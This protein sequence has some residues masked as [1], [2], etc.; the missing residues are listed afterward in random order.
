MNEFIDDLL[1]ALDALWREKASLYNK[2][3]SDYVRGQMNVVSAAKRAL[4]AVKEKNQLPVEI[5]KIVNSTQQEAEK[6]EPLTMDQLKEMDGQPVWIVE[7]P[8]WGH[9]ELSEDAE[10]Y[11]NDRDPDFYGMKYNDPCGRYGL[12]A[13]GWLAYRHPPKEVHSD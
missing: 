6:S 3:Q 2:T 11:L 12:H 5:T 9:W 1:N 4:T 8:D 7:A 13:L 10:E